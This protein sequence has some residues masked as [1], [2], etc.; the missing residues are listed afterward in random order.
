M[1]LLETPLH[2]LR[3]RH[4]S[5][6]FPLGPGGRTSRHGPRTTTIAPRRT[7]LAHKAKRW[8]PILNTRTHPS[9]HTNKHK[10]TPCHPYR[11]CIP[12]P[13]QLFPPSLFEPAIA[14]EKAQHPPTSHGAAAQVPRQYQDY[15]EAHRNKYG[16]LWRSGLVRYILAGEEVM[17]NGRR[18]LRGF[19]WFNDKKQKTQGIKILAGR[20]DNS[21][22]DACAR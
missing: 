19:V 2:T 13:S 10:R 1:G 20:F 15:N 7:H 4:D 14:V 22:P 12:P 8:V 16:E 21:Q 6:C 9:P 5:D 11:S 18:V 17:P 3:R